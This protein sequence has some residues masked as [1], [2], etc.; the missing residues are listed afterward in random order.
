[1]TTTPI[2]V[3]QSDNRVF[4]VDIKQILLPEWNSRVEFDP[5]D[6]AA[7][8]SS[9]RESGVRTPIRVRATPKAEKPFTL[10]YGTRRYKA[11]LALGLSTIPALVDPEIPEM[12]GKSH[13]MAAMMDNAVENLA[14][15]DLSP[16][17]QA[18]TFAELRKAGWKLED[19]SKKTGVTK[20]HISNLA[21][22]YT[23]VDPVILTEWSKGNPAAKTDYLRTLPPLDKALQVEA[24]RAREAQLSAAAVAEGDEEELQDPDEDDE[25]EVT[26]PD[27]PAPPKKYAVLKSR[28]DQLLRRL[29]V[30]KQ[31]AICAEVVNYLIG[32]SETVKN[33]IERDE[34]TADAL[35]KPAKKK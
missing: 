6:D 30:T 1:M 29:K 31:P 16:F 10:V 34:E 22:I 19:V 20:G 23:M 25:E 8:E 24:F 13:L 15:K 2:A 21:T 12:A 3:S 14:R 28:A 32:K 35:K 33:V 27:R 4:D 18:R 17:E 26:S 5:A 7:L 9:I 11:S